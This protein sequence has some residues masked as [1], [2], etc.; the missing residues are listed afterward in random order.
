[1]AAAPAPVL[2]AEQERHAA[3]RAQT[4][5]LWHVR[6][7]VTRHTA[8]LTGQDRKRLL[9]HILVHNR[10]VA[11]RARGVPAPSLTGA[12]LLGYSVAQAQETNEARL[13]EVVADLLTF[14]AGER[15]CACVL[16]LVPPCMC[17]SVCLCGC[18]ICVC[19]PTFAS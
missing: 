14:G 16:M 15:V 4:D 10:C 13:L 18:G 2:T 12:A 19:P 1:M 17:L 11:H 3:L 7:A 9:H 6:D 8:H 5:A